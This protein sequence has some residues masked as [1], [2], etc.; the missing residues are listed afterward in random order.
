MGIYF[1]MFQPSHQ[2]L[3]V[4]S[5]NCIFLIY[6]FIK[7]VMCSKV[8]SDCESEANQIVSYKVN[9]HLVTKSLKTDGNIVSFEPILVN[10]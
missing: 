5:G 4:V 6:L 7:F 1:T 8:T 3:C 9:K 2:S 10:C